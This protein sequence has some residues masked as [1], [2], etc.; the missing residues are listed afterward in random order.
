MV[1]AT[2]GE[3]AWGAIQ[4]GGI[5]IALLDWKMP[6]M[7]GIEVCRRVRQSPGDGYLYVMLLTARD[8]VEDVV[9][10]LEAGADDYLRK[11]YSEEEL[12]S[13]IHVGERIVALER[14]LALHAAQLQKAL[15]NIRVLKGLLPI[16]MYCKKIRDDRDYWHQIEAYLHEHTEAGF[17]HSICPECRE[18]IVKPMLEELKKV[19]EEG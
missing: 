18:K 16:C 5:D 2:D 19:N 15:D 4:L 7:E 14:N 9:A 10:G 8:S 11:P 3:Q 1:T 12:H 17:T 6:K 13:R